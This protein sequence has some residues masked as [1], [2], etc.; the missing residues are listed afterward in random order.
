[1]NH[2]IKR[3][4]INTGGGDAPGLNA[5]THAA[6]YAARAFMATSRW[7]LLDSRSGRLSRATGT[8]NRF[9]APPGAGRARRT[10]NDQVTPAFSCGWATER[11]P[12]RQVECGLS[13]FSHALAT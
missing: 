10:V 9:G 12:G 11:E 3:I 4:A 2:D 1:M 6:V 5:V 13:W 8:I 7:D